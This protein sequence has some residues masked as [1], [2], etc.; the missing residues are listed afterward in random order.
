MRFLSLL[1]LVAIASCA[2]LEG[3][4]DDRFTLN[5]RDSPERQLFEVSLTSH[6]P[7]RL[8]LSPEMWPNS[9]G[10]MPAAPQTATV[11]IGADH[12]PIDGDYNSGYCIGNECSVQVPPRSTITGTILYERFRIPRDLV[13]SPKVLEFHPRPY[14]C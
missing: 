14:I 1:F 3:Q 12:F 10:W 13:Q 2:T 5:V 8:C 7:Y 9:H 11:A 4:P 6:S